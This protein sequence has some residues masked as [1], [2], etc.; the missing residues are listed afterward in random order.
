MIT[1]WLMRMGRVL[2][3]TLIG[4]V[5]PFTPPAFVASGAASVADVLAVARSLGHWV[6]IE[7]FAG[8]V[9]AVLSCLVAG[10]TIKLVRI[11]ASFLTV[12]G[13]SAG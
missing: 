11:V 12:G 13:G 6:P 8:V 5:P 7:L 3:E 2:V 9:V 1:E 10:A 4:A